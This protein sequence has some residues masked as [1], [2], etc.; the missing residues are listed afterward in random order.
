MVLTRTNPK[1]LENTTLPTIDSIW[2][3]RGSNA[4]FRLSRDAFC[5]LLENPHSVSC[6]TVK[7]TM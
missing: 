2:T 1:Y 6:D 7:V 5:V 4:G 3:G